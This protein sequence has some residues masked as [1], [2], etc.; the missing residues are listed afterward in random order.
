M[1]ADGGGTSKKESNT[2]VLACF[3]RE[4]RTRD[5]GISCDAGCGVRT[6]ALLAPN[7]ALFISLKRVSGL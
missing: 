2:D 6:S 1:S 5:E 7:A 4:L 3:P